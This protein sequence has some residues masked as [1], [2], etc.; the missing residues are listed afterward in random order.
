[1]IV[2]SSLVIIPL[3]WSNYGCLSAL[4]LFGILM[5]IHII[6]SLLISW[7]KYNHHKS[8]TAMKHT[9]IDNMI[10]RCKEWH[11]SDY[12]EWQRKQMIKR[13]AD[14]AYLNIDIENNA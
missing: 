12:E 10:S 1:M 14:L 6:G 4:K 8:Y 2:W 3:T 9:L 13:F 5:L 11:E 7:V